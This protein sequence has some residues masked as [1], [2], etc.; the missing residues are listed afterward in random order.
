[1]ACHQLHKSANCILQWRL[2]NEREWER[3]RNKGVWIC[4]RLICGRVDIYGRRNGPLPSGRSY[5]S[6]M[7]L[8]A[9][10]KNKT[11]LYG[12]EDATV[13]RMK[14]MMI[15]E[16]G[17][18]FLFCL[19]SI[20]SLLQSSENCFPAIS[21]FISCDWWCD[22][23][24]S[25]LSAFIPSTCPNQSVVNSGPWLVRRR[26]LISGI[27]SPDSSADLYK[28]VCSNTLLFL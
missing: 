28:C 16:W 1:M 24:A 10:G 20:L 19:V 12:S 14:M 17:L 25:K 27:I 22:V 18:N 23:T 11:M 6:D 9:V 15:L 8:S 13:M 7:K 21:Q 3:E 5:K 2:W 26:W 4:L